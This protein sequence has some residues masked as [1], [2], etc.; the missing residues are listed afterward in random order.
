MNSDRLSKKEEWAEEWAQSDVMLEFDPNAVFFRDIHNLCQRH[1]PYDKNMKC[2]EVGCYPGTYMWYFNKF[3]GYQASGIEYVEECIAPC[4]KFMG[5]LGIDAE[6][7]YGDFFE[8]SPEKLWDVVVSFGFIEHFKD[9]QAVIQQHLDMIQPGGYLVL[10]IPNHAGL[11][12]TILKFLDQEKYKIHNLMSYKDMASGLKDTKQAEILEG[13][14]YGHIGFWNAALYPKIANWPRIPHFVTQKS[15]AVV[16][17]AGAY[18][19]PNTRY[20]SPNSAL[21]ARKL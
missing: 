1:L 3:F 17:R 10:V 8:Y 11:N 6:I 20:L 9:T 16:E 4:K 12:G 2:L 21:I 13:G 5:S 18:I 7:I 19:V 14:Y 15:L